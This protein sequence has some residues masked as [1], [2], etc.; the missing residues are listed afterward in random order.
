[1]DQR[2]NREKPEGKPHSVQS[3]YK[4]TCVIELRKKNVELTGFRKK[5]SEP[6][7]FSIIICEIFLHSQTTVEKWAA[8]A[9]G[10]TGPTSKRDSVHCKSVLVRRRKKRD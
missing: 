9:A 6:A 1:M 8:A 4:T 3:I 7:A 2:F 5:N 10:R